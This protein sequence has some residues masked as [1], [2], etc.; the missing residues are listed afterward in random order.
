LIAILFSIHPLSVEAV[1]W[2][3]GRKD[4]LYGFFFLLSWL[5]YLQY[6]GNRKIIFYVCSLLLFVCS[7]LCKVQAITLPFVLIVSD[8]ILAGK[9]RFKE[10]TG[11]IPFI[12]IAA[13]FGFAAVTGSTLVADKY[14]VEPAFMEKVV[15]SI[16]ATGL[17]IT[18]LLVPVNQSASY[19]FPVTNSSEYWTLLL[20][21][22][23]TIVAL[24][25]TAVYYF[26][27][28]KFISGGI[29]YF[30]ISIAVV[31]HVFAF[32]SSLIYERFTY[33]A[34]IGFFI[35]L[36]FL[37]GELPAIS[38]YSIRVPAIMIVIFS[39]L[40][41]IRIGVWKD[42]ERLWTDVIEKNPSAAMG[43]NNRGM[44]YYERGDYDKA[45]S[46]FNESIKV[47]PRHPDAY[48]NRSVIF[49]KQKKYPYALRENQKVLEIDS[50]HREGYSNRASFFY[51]MQNYDSAEYYYLKAS[52][53]FPNN[54]ASYFYTGVSRFNKKEY[55]KALDPLYKAISIIPDY[56]DAYV[57][58][59]LCYV[60]LDLKDSVKYCINKAESFTPLTAARESAVKE[61]KM[62]G[63]EIF[64][65]GDWQKALRYY[66]TVLEL[67]PNDAEALYDIGGVYLSRQNVN[68][69]REYWKKSLAINPQQNEA[70]TWLAKIGN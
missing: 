1:A 70:R 37:I 14:S 3:A 33:L 29:L 23:F 22:V 7:L 52:T 31:M 15:Y 24:T 62:A 17:Y 67:N 65:S 36:V 38:K 32:N 27:K 44:V 53:H 46:D 18:K 10:I 34:S 64:N 39:I 66:S 28:N 56:A 12:L 55:R 4:V 47:Q 21:G 48:N 30:F 13:G 19:A 9:F 6:S 54:A 43:W 11:K 40:A 59:G 5:F 42:S 68:L 61:Y 58:L 49:F 16:M 50:M 51:A 57:F 41:F 26:R 20:W 25:G 8:Y 45:L 35:S 69:A 60:R 63:N 2:V